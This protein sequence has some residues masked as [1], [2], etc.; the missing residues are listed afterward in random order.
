MLLPSTG[1]TLTGDVIVSGNIGQTHFGYPYVFLVIVFRTFHIFPV[2]YY[3]TP[4]IP[5]AVWLR[6]S[7]RG[8]WFERFTKRVEG[9]TNKFTSRY[10]E[11]LEE[12][13][14]PR[15]KAG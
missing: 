5:C 9:S 6:L 15:N 8:Q 12:P 11:A 14:W 13:P 10:A 7:L 1:D 4:P 2:Y 3:Y